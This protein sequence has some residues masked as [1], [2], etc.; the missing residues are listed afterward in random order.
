MLQFHLNQLKT[1]VE[2]LGLKDL[3]PYQELINSELK[4]LDHFLYYLNDQ[5]M[6]ELLAIYDHKHFKLAANETT[7]E[8]FE[9]I[10][11]S[12]KNLRTAQRELLVSFYHDPK[13]WSKAL[14]QLC[15]FYVDYI[16]LIHCAIF[17]A[18]V[19]TA[20]KSMQN[21]KTQSGLIAQNRL[22]AIILAPMQRMPRYT[23]LAKEILKALEE[24]MPNIAQD[25]QAKAQLF[26]EHTQDFYLTTKIACVQINT[27]LAELE[28]WKLENDDSMDEE[29]TSPYLQPS[30]RL[31]PHKAQTPQL[32][33]KKQSQQKRWQSEKAL[34]LR[35]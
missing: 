14:N 20:F 3:Y 27:C 10:Y 30:G 8:K 28:Q 1:I 2:E 18:K 24:H 4:Y 6:Q 5:D 31:K 19:E 21:N 13:A 26:L 9:A 22:A 17:P 12:L 11:Q 35:K 15:P 7:K 33:R 23:L 16:K 25:K 32:K 29:P 34:R